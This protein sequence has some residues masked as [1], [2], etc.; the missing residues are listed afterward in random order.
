VARPY[1]ARPPLVRSLG[2]IIASR[3]VSVLIDAMDLLPKTLQARL[4]I[5]GKFETSA[6]EQEARRKPGWKY[7]DYAGWQ[8]RHG[9][10]DLLSRARV[11]VVPLLPVPNNI[12]AQAIKL[13][14][15]MIAGLPVVAT[16]LPR[17]GEIV[18]EAQCGILVEP[19]QPK[20][21]AEAIQWLLEHPAEAQAMGKRGHQAILQT[22]N[23]DS[24]AQLLLYL[25]HRVTCRS[26]SSPAAFSLPQGEV[27]SARHE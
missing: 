7:T 20:A 16:N 10:L 2:T 22:Y 18:R 8:N 4:A 11:G 1:I 13:F 24:Q 19:G 14:E 26:G 6:L 15:Y 5:G 17:Q 12:D 3:G 25:Y 9:L 23:W 27:P 21:L